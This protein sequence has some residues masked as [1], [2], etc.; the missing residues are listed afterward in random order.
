MS[1]SGAHTCFLA[2]TRSLLLRSA[3]LL[4]TLAGGAWFALV[5]PGRTFLGCGGLVI[6][7]V[8]VVAAV[9]GGAGTYHSLESL[10]DVSGGALQTVLT[11]LR[12]VC[13]SLQQVQRLG[14]SV[15]AL[16]LARYNC[17]QIMGETKQ[18]S[19]MGDDEY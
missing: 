11:R 8:G 7:G 19:R 10:L 5:A 17:E 18:L 1:T 15:G 16:V 12:L 9:C 3:V 13:L 4:R 2:A 6:V 14:H